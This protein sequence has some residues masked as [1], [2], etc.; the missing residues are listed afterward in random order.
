MKP[1]EEVKRELVRQWL[2]KAEGDYRLVQHLASDQTE[3]FGAIGFHS[4][5]AVEKFLKAMLVWH[6]VEFPK[7]HDM[8]ELLDLLARSEPDVARSLQDATVLSGYSVDVRYPSDMPQISLEDA[9]RAA[10]LASEVRKTILNA[11]QGHDAQSAC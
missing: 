6:Q 8:Q 11:L 2:D 7:T 4:Q 3:F 9:K 10:E 1:P 5:Q